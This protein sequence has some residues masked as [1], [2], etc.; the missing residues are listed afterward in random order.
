MRFPKAGEIMGVLDKE[1]HEY[2][3]RARDG[4]IPEASREGE[5]LKVAQSVTDQWKQIIKAYNQRGDTV[6]PIL[7]VYQRLRG[8]YVPSEQ[9]NYLTKV[10]SVGLTLM[11][12]IMACSLG[13]VAW[14]ALKRN[15]F[16][17]K[18]SQ[19]PFLCLICFGT[20]IMASSIVPM[21]IDDSIADQNGCNKAC[22]ATPWLLAIGF[23]VCF[24]ALFAKI[25]RLNLMM[26]KAKRFRRVKV[27][28]KDVLLPFVLLLVVNV[29]LLLIWTLVDPL[30]WERTYQGRTEAGELES[31]G[32][33]TTSGNAGLILLALIAVANI[34][35]VILA[36]V[37]AYQTRELKSAY[38]ESKYV[39]LAMA[40]ILQAFLIGVQLL[41]LS[42]SSPTARYLVRSILVFVI[43][44][45]VLLFIFVPKMFT[46]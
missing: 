44:M 34:I 46:G 20:L 3:V 27:T 41:F 30:F 21:S 8:V 38:S 43:C 26:K 12:V 37:Q 17:V 32:R 19:P 11:A 1:V 24:A 18:A 31:S 22:M 35:A 42:E 6:A 28:A 25:Q 5:R 15:T 29:I 10:R 40:S 39:G 36:N 14:V 16:V 9:K 23:S 4:L 33:C 45:A 2:L 7:E 13:A